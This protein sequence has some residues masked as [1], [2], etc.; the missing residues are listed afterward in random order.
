LDSACVLD[1]RT[2]SLRD[3][4]PQPASAKNSIE[5]RPREE[6]AKEKGEG[7]HFWVKV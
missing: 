7:P 4:T 2:L 3:C 1:A 5:E 6:M